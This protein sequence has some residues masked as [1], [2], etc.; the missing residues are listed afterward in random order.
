MGPKTNVE[1]AYPLYLVFVSMLTFPQGRAGPSPSDAGSKNRASRW[2][3]KKIHGEVLGAFN[4]RQ[5]GIA[6]C[7]LLRLPSSTAVT[8]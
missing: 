2:S 5:T 6:K 3:T 4:C 8:I 1:I 7:D